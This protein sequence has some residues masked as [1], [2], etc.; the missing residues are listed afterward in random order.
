V[1]GGRNLRGRVLLDADEVRTAM[2]TLDPIPLKPGDTGWLVSDDGPAGA[3]AK[4][5]RVR[6]GGVVAWVELLEDA[7]QLRRG[8]W[9][10]VSRADFAVDVT[11]AA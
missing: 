4:V 9:V 11:R 3:R 2:H 6:A 5:M 10:L 8:E 7:G 1:F